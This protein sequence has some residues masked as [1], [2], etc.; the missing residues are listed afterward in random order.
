MSGNILVAGVMSGTSL[1]GLDVAFC[2]FG[3]NELN[4]TFQIEFAET[5]PYTKEWQNLLSSSFHLPGNELISLHARYGEFIG[6]SIVRLANENNLTPDLIASHGHTVFHRPDQGYT[7]QLGCGATIAA[8]TGTDTVCDFRSLDIA[9]GGQG[10]PLVPMGDR[11]LFSGH[12]FCLNLGGIANISFDKNEDVIAFD[13]CPVN[14]ALN[15]LAAEAGQECDTDG[16]L[17]AAGKINHILLESLNNLAY[18]KDNIRGSLSRE[19]FEQNF[20]PLINDKSIPLND[21]LRTVCEH[22]AKQI[23]LTM[24]S[25]PGS[26]LL[27]TGGGALNLFLTELIEDYISPHGVH[28]VIPEVELIQFKEAL[29][30]AFLGLL[31]YKENMNTFASV[32]GARRNSSG[33]CIYLS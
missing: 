17:A 5:I 25:A 26:T 14:M 3:S 15:C 18:Y 23:S 32:T 31:R 29:I 33:G 9:L 2:S 12:R 7:F 1:D 13:I 4:P 8:V 11:M 19:W 22:I 21:R 24:F 28:I 16:E 6:N 10:A 30:F 20:L 27:T